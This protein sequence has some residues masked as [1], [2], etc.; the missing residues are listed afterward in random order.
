M[1]ASS[2]NRWLSLNRTLYT[3]ARPRIL[4]HKGII[5]V[6]MEVSPVTSVDWFKE[7][8]IIGIGVASPNQ[9]SQRLAPSLQAHQSVSAL[10]L[11]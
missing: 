8:C 10:W 2:H 7:D 9:L 6:N 5:V 3:F 11:L 1:L 4:S